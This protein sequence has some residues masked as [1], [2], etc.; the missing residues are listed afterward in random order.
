MTKIRKPV[1]RDITIHLQSCSQRSSHTEIN[2]F[3][4][5]GVGY[6]KLGDSGSR[7]KCTEKI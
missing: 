5:R 2:L 4:M 6:G 7:K 1:H 3:W